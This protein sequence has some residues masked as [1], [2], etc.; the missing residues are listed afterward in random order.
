[1]SERNEGGQA[2]QLSC[3]LKVF[4]DRRPGTHHPPLSSA[5]LS[6]KPPLLPRAS[7]EPSTTLQAGVRVRERE[8]VKKDKRGER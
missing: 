1:M 4:K 2:F 6:H 8:R 3:A 7:E 5:A